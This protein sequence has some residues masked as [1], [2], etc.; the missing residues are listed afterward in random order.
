M[1]IFSRILT[2]SSFLLVAAGGFSSAHAAVLFFSFSPN[3]ICLQADDSSNSRVV[4]ARPCANTFNQVW[5]W[6]DSEIQGLGTSVGIDGVHEKCL[7]VRGGGKA[8]GTLVQIFEC[9]GTGA[10]EWIYT[11]AG[12]IFNPQSGKCLD[13]KT[14]NGNPGEGQ[15]PFNEYQAVIQTC[16]NSQIWAVQ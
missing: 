9:N 1:S 4:F 15:N 14:I 7:D 3:V 10:Q 8:D 13:L 11:G 12:T 16:N 5:N 2:L 6:E